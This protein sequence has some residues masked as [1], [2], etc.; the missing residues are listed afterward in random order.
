[1]LQRPS[2][3]R[4]GA[5]I[6]TTTNEFERVGHDDSGRS[7]C[8]MWWKVPA[9][10][11]FPLGEHPGLHQRAQHT[12]T[13]DFVDT[14]PFRRSGRRQRQRRVVEKVG[15]DSHHEVFDSVTCCGHRVI[16]QEIGQ[17]LFA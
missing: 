13:F 17:C 15:L 4:C 2:L 16:L 10:G 6:E 9:I 12:S 1:M 5:A 8:H 14:E 11:P 3:A 7:P